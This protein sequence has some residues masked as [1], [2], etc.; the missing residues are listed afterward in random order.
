MDNCSITET[1]C[2]YFYED[3]SDCHLYHTVE[4]VKQLAYQLEEMKE[5]N[6][7]E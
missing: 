2:P 7:N 3:C 1:I 6:R 5:M 4:E